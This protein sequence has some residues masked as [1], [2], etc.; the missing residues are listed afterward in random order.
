MWE[1]T[2]CI[3]TPNSSQVFVIIRSSSRASCSRRASA[4]GLLEDAYCS[5]RRAAFRACEA[6][7]QDNWKKAGAR[8]MRTWRAWCLV[9]LLFWGASAT[10]AVFCNETSVRTV[11]A[12]CFATVSFESNCAMRSSM[13][14]SSSEICSGGGDAALVGERS[15]LTLLRFEPAMASMGEFVIDLSED[16]AVRSDLLCEPGAQRTSRSDLIPC[17]SL[18][19][20]RVALSRN[21]SCGMLGDEMRVKERRTG[22]GSRV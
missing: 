20:R 10:S 1:H 5:A 11:A 7:D 14:A 4:S 8:A 16:Q 6:C 12:S 21:T 15:F 13:S 17:M 2:S 3:L 19:G 18:S 22:G 9:L